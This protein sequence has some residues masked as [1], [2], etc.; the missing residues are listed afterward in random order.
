[1]WVY[2]L[3]P[4]C[5]DVHR[6]FISKHSCA[7]SSD[8]FSPSLSVRNSDKRISCDEEFSDS[9]DEGEGGRKNVANFKKAKRVKT[10]EEKEEEEKKGEHESCGWK[11]SWLCRA[12]L[13]YDFLLLFHAFFCSF[14]FS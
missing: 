3:L 2:W 13:M 14:F 11:P 9:E 8:L 5:V 4:M 6:G 1:M 10:E 12:L 7:L